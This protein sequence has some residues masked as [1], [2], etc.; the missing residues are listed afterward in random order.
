[1]KT[2]FDRTRSVPVVRHGQEFLLGLLCHELFLLARSLLVI[3][4]LFLWILVLHLCLGQILFRQLPSA[5]ILLLGLF[6]VNL[7]QTI[8]LCRLRFWLLLGRFLGLGVSRF[9]FVRLLCLLRLIF[10]FLLL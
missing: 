5:C 2:A 8:F 3:L 1:M 9:L 7:D 6:Q 10:D 4:V